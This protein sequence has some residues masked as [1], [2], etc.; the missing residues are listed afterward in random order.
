MAYF[1]GKTTGSF[2]L[3]LR[4][5]QQKVDINSDEKSVVFV[6][7]RHRKFHPYVQLWKDAAFL[8]FRLNET[9]ENMIFL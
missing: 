3:L 4:Y 7:M 9:L 5:H 2:I 8:H 6:T 1:S